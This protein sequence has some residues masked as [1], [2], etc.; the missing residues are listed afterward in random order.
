MGE[1][2]AQFITEPLWLKSE[3]P[4]NGA[5]SFLMVKH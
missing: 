1:G 3:L 4:E 2:K 5:L